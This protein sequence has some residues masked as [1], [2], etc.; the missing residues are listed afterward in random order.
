MKGKKLTKEEFIEK[1][2][3]IHNNEYDYSLIEYINVRTQVKII[4]SEHGVFEQKPLHHLY[5]GHGCWK[6][7]KTYKNNTK[8]FI[9]K[10]LELHGNKY[11][12]SKVV[13]S[14]NRKKVEI[15]CLKHRLFL[16]ATG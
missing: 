5:R 7:S 10:S 1:G 3:N 12:Y 8:D 2:K 14:G 15:V 11:D 9:K 13:Y 16:A 4:C 6:C